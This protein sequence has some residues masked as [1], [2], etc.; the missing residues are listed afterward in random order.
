MGYIA[1]LSIYHQFI[2]SLKYSAIK[3][4]RISG[5]FNIQLAA[6]IIKCTFKFFTV[7]PVITQT[8][9]GSRKEYYAGY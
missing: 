5:V 8:P 2:T 6:I 1:S 3:S 7:V 4:P 9:H